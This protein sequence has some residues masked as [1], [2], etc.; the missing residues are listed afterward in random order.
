MFIIQDPTVC[1]HTAFNLHLQKNSILKFIFNLSKEKNTLFHTRNIG[2]HD[3]WISF[4][5][6]PTWAV[7]AKTDSDMHVRNLL[8]NNVSCLA[9]RLNMFPS[10]SVC[11]LLGSIPHGICSGPI[12]QLKH[13]PDTHLNSNMGGLGQKTLVHQQSWF[14]TPTVN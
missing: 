11:W 7:L 2:F 9:V 6:V 13:D 10:S 1:V 3:Y 12:S 5:R 8:V 4:K 14:G